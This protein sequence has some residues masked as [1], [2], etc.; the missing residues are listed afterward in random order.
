MAGDFAEVAPVF[1]DADPRDRGPGKHV[2]IIDPK[3]K[4]H[5]PGKERTDFIVKPVEGMMGGVAAF[6]DLGTQTAA[7][8]PDAP[9]TAAPRSAAE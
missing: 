6:P 7:G 9:D 2:G 4:Q 1:R 5:D 8:D 3:F